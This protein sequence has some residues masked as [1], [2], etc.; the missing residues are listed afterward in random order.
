MEE[1][2]GSG[3]R[4]IHLRC[5]AFELL[6]SNDPD[7]GQLPIPSAAAVAVKRL[8]P[9]RSPDSAPT[10]PVPCA[11]APALPDDAVIV[12]A[13]NL[14]TFYRAP[15]PGAAPYVEI[16]STIAAGEELCLIEVMKLFTAVR[17]DFGGEVLAILAEDGAMVEQGAPL[18]AIRRTA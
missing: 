7:A 15:K 6:L 17:A 10:A 12:C 3:V 4:T 11:A 9:S 8:N 2:V 18:L 13:P 5:G 16:G 1:F 14:G